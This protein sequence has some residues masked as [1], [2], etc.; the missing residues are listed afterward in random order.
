MRPAM[1]AFPRL[2]APQSFCA[3][4]Q[5]PAPFSFCASSQG[6]ARARGARQTQHSPLLPPALATNRLGCLGARGRRFCIVLWR[7][8]EGRVMAGSNGLAGVS[9]CLAAKHTARHM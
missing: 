9:D 2:P 4:S 3:S 6:Q 7:A 1:T 8:A 5:L